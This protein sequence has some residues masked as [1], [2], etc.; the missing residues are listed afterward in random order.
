MGAAGISVLVDRIPAPVIRSGGKIRRSGA[1]LR[2]FLVYVQDCLINLRVDHD[3]GHRWSTVDETEGV[4]SPGG[5]S[6]LKPAGACFG[7]VTGHSPARLCIV[8]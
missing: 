4:K 7:I 5:H 1:S 6:G 2:R 3:A 8:V